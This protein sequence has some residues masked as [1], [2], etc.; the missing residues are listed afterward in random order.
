MKV[1]DTDRNGEISMTEM[2]AAFSKYLAWWE[3]KLAGSPET[4]LKKIDTDNND[5]I[6]INEMKEA[7]KVGSVTCSDL[8]NLHR[9]FCN[10]YQPPTTTNE[11]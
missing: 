4:W 11:Q 5:I 10:R 8:A 2:K 1:F 7:A 6:T 3:A 9:F